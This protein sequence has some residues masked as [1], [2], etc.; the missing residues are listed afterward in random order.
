MPLLCHPLRMIVSSPIL[1]VFQSIALRSVH[2]PF[3]P[4]RQ[5]CH[6]RFK[7]EREEFP[8]PHHIHSHKSKPSGKHIGRKIIP[9]KHQNEIRRNQK[10]MFWICSHTLPELDFMLVIQRAI[11]VRNSN[12]NSN[13]CSVHNI[14]W[15]TN[16]GR[17]SFLLL[18]RLHLSSFI[19]QSSSF[20]LISF[21]K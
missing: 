16:K 8:R 10:N 5:M 21:N 6:Q 18:V 13:S 4:L 17:Q 14:F 2:I 11:Q 1:V 12:S 3:L 9:S 19:S 20:F 7:T 15:F